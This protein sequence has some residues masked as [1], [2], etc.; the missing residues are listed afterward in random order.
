MEQVQLCVLA[1]S[2]SLNLIS[3]QSWDS[4]IKYVYVLHWYFLIVQRLQM[5]PKLMWIEKEEWIKELLLT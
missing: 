5:S 1:S 4:Q 3:S 2:A